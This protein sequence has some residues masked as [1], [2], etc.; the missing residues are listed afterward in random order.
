MIVDLSVVIVNWNTRDLLR[1]CLR[2]LE[3]FPPTGRYEVIVVDNASGDDSADMVVKEF[4]SV[5]LVRSAIN[6]GFGRANNLAVAQSSGAQI[7]LLNPDTLV[8]PGTIAATQD[9]L[10]SHPNVGM[11]GVRQIQAD[12]AAQSSC[13]HFPSLRVMFLQSALGLLCALGLSSVVPFLAGL[14]GLRLMPVKRL[15]RFW[16]FTATASVD[17]VMGAYM[18][19]PRHVAVRTKMFDERFVVYGEDLDL[20]WRVRQLGLDVVYFGAASITH[21]GGASTAAISAKADAAHFVASIMLYE[22]HHG[23]LAALTYRLCLLIGFQ[24]RMLLS[25]LRGQ[26]LRQHAQTYWYRMRAVLRPT[27]AGLVGS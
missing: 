2:S 19:M 22:K 14:F 3:C 17:W 9:F 16:D 8:H 24:V 18:L 26:H 21:F 5:R 11:V 4:P 7:L 25:L 1:D 10:K 15:R 23:R 12:G 13:G 20:C 27:F 6:L